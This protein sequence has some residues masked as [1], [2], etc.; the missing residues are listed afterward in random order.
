MAD[1]LGAVSGA[2][3]LT[4]SGEVVKLLIESYSDK[5]R[6]Q[7]LKSF[8]AFINPDEYTLNYNVIVDKTYVPGKNSN[9][10]SA[11]LQIQPLEVSLK[12]FLDGTNVVVDK[13][14][15][16]KLDVPLKIGQFHEVIGYDGKV[17]KPRYLKL[18]WGKAAWLRTN[19][20]SFDCLLKSASFQYKLFDKQG[21]P[22][23]V[24]INAS[25]IEVL[26]PPIAQAEDKKK[27]PDLTHVRIVQEGDTLPSMAYKI[28]GDFKYYLE[29][30]KANNMKNFRN[31]QPGQ[32][33]FF[34]PFD[35]KV[36]NN[37]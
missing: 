17:H 35:R 5:E 16:G 26:S 14:T 25:F 28:Y 4:D 21:S 33:L 23:R 22:L 29:V 15:G 8:V 9:D 34:P 7:D 10:L 18:I 13:A 12:F 32:K 6:T 36:K 11:F 30:A 27:S 1:I 37:A 2:L 19:Q 31:L 20:Y 3:G 24:L